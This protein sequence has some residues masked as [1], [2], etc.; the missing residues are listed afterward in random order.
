M[1][2]RFGDT[3]MHLS[4]ASIRKA[5]PKDKPYKLNDGHGLV[6]LVKPSGSRLWQVR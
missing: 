5:K 3:H 1:I 6:L 2:F 4:D